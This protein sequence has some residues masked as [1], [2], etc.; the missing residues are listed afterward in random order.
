MRLVSR[1]AVVGDRRPARRRPGATPPFGLP[2]PDRRPACACGDTCSTCAAR[3]TAGTGRAGIAL[4]AGRPL[5]PGVRDSMASRFGV[6]LSA[7]R[8]H[9][10]PP[11][12]DA[13]ARLRASAFTIGTDIAFAAGRYDPASEVG[14]RLIAHELAHVVQQS[15]TVADAGGPT[16]NRDRALE[17]AAD[18]AADAVLAGAR[19]GPSP[20]LAAPALQL[21]D[22]APTKPTAEDVWG[23]RVDASMCGCFDTITEDLAHAEKSI[24]EYVDC[25][26][27]KNPTAVDVFKC[28][29]PGYP[30]SSQGLTGPGGTSRLPPDSGDPCRRLHN[31]NVATHEARHGQQAAG[32][33]QQ[34]GPEFVKLFRK[35]QGDPD[36]ESKMRAQFPTQMDEYARQWNDGHNAAQ[37][38]VG[39]YR[40]NMQFLYAARAALNRICRK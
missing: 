36:F 29:D 25:D 34:F 38:E 26:N 1:P 11:A 6:D 40:F 39:A 2:A 30:G 24:K 9:T 28:V 37:R 5:D 14:R 7:V 8:V 3:A 13:A 32:M 35:L 10:D 19:P 27:P 18:R 20:T 21:D 31:K 15:L 23:F 22:E 4:A 16:V 33:A 17:R 12:A